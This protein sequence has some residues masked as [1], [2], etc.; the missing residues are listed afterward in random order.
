MKKNN[1]EQF[2]LRY[3]S[4]AEKDLPITVKT[5]IHL[6]TLSTWR[7]KNI[8]PRADDALKIADALDTTVD[9]LVS[10]KKTAVGVCSR[11]HNSY[12]DRNRKTF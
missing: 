3:K 2:W 6:S 12:R 8:F 5:G 10:G 1:A 11:C 9:Y 4:L 7:R